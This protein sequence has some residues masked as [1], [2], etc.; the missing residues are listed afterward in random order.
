MFRPKVSLWTFLMK[1][2]LYCRL[3][4][5]PSVLAWV[6]GVQLT[7][8]KVMEMTTP[9]QSPRGKRRPPRTSNCRAACGE[10]PHDDRL[11]CWNP[12]KPCVPQ[13]RDEISPGVT[14]AKAERN[15]WMAQGANLNAVLMGNQQRS[16]EQGN[17]QRL[18]HA[19]VGPSGPK[20]FA[21]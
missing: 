7:S 9:A 21:P 10:S 8:W 2:S 4:L 12:L 5:L 14:V 20:W 15:A 18:S 17:V 6:S 13:H 3:S 11:N 19:G 16:P 1:R